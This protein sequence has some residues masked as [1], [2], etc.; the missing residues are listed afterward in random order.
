MY[1]R[2]LANSVKE[3]TKL[4]PEHLLF[5]VY[6]VEIQVSEDDL[7]DKMLGKCLTCAVMFAP[8]DNVI[9]V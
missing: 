9:F 8:G 6:Y 2:C 4:L 5:V 1:L 3:L 7:Y